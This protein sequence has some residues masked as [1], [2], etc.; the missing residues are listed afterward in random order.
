MQ[1]E[2]NQIPISIELYCCLLDKRLRD[3]QMG[4][5]GERATI[6]EFVVVA[7]QSGLRQAMVVTCWML[8]LASHMA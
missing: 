5:I 2:S 8:L 7:W 3:G 4:R 1:N 6:P